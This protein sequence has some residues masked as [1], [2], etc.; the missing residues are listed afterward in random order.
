MP[1][2][3]RAEI[4]RKILAD[5]EGAQNTIR[6]RYLTDLA[7]H[8]ERDAVLYASDFS[9]R[10]LAATVNSDDIGGLMEALRGLQN[11]RLDLILHSP[12]GSLEAAEQIG[13]Y[14]RQK[15]AHIRAIIPQNAM[16]AATVIACACDEIV[17]GKHSALGPTDPQLNLPDSKGFRASAQNI[18]DE[19]QRARNDMKKNPALGSLWMPL[20]ERY[21]IGILQECEAAIDHSR[22]VVN[23]WLAGRMFKGQKTAGKKAKDIANWLASREQHKSHGRPIGIAEAKKK[24]LKIVALEDNQKF[25]E[26]ALSAFHAT[27]VTFSVTPTIKILESHKGQGYQVSVRVESPKRD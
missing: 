27:M 7:R 17:M 26:I 20:I 22:E 18:L 21:P 15:Y 24:G 25:Q 4:Q 14:L 8:S 13:S 16:S 3:G 2:P 5:K 10:G 23:E 1:G 12:G 6:V 19:F 11:E 9:G